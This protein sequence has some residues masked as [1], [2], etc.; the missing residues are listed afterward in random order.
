MCE[1]YSGGHRCTEE[2]ISKLGD[3]IV[4]TNLNSRK[5]IDL[6]IMRPVRL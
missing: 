2:S 6:K 1:E 5:R 4:K 3:G